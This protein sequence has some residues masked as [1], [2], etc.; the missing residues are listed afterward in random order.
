M[1]GSKFQTASDE[2]KGFAAVVPWQSP[3]GDAS[4]LTAVSLVGGKRPKAWREDAG[5]SNLDGG[6]KVS[7][8]RGCLG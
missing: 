3:K 2:A 6:L 7:Y 1:L 8:K 5:E 4:W